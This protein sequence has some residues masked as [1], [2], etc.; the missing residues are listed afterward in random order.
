[1]KIYIHSTDTVWGVGASYLDEESILLI[2]NIKSNN[3]K[4]PMSLLCDNLNQLESL[5]NIPKNKE[6]IL[7]LYS[8]AVTILFPLKWCR[9]KM[10]SYIIGNSKYVGIRIIK[11]L[12][13]LKTKTSDLIITT[14]SLNLQNEPPI[15]ELNE[16]V[17]FNQKYF[18]NTAEMLNLGVQ[19]SSQPST[20]IQIEDSFNIKIIREG[21]ALDEIKAKLKL[22]STNIL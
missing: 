11:F 13:V 22:F 16:A 10:P 14:T 3:L 15:T 21:V 17:R 12:D 5:I 6:A 1:M 19:A 8:H 20:I 4:K 18:E 2:K 9:K 7:S